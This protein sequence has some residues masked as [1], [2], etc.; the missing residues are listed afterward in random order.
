MTGFGRILEDLNGAGVRYVLIG[1]IALIRHGVVRA[2]RDVDAVFDPEK[3]NV[4]MAR[5][6]PTTTLPGIVRFISRPSTGISICFLRNQ[7]ARFN[8]QRER[9][10]ELR[11]RDRRRELERI[12]RA[13]AG[14]EKTLEKREAEARE[15]PIEFRARAELVATERTLAER[16]ELAVTAACIDPPAY[17]AKELGER[18]A[19]PEKPR[20]REAGVRTI[21]GYRQ[22]HGVKDQN[23]AFGGAHD[24]SRSAER[25]REQARQRLQQTQREMSR[26]KETDRVRDM[27]HSMEIGL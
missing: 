19:D 11:R 14:A 10:K 15:K 9:A 26:S 7:P 6:F 8:T 13:E 21:E 23:H 25:A 24:S 18:P 17:I 22:E 1:G 16:R 5:P 12:D 27:G 4:Q 3:D 2:T 20:S